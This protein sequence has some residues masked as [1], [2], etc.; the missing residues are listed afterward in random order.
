MSSGKQL[1]IE[2]FPR[3]RLDAALLCFAKA[4][5]VHASQCPAPL[6][7]VALGLRQCPACARA[8]GVNPDKADKADKANTADKADMPYTPYKPYQK[9]S[10]HTTC[11]R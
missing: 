2:K 3:Q 10:G 1:F 5:T 6:A 4:R 8:R 7:K 9:A 11:A